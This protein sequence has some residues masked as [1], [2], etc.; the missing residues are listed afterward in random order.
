[1]YDI[2]DAIVAINPNAE[3][4]VIDEKYETIAWR[5]G[6]PVIAKADI[7]AKQLELK[8]AWEAQDYARKRKVEYDKLNQWEMWFD[9]YTKG[10]TVWKDAINAIKAKY[11]KPS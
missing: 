8:K 6:T 5:N 1:M 9:D 11:P 2:V 4:T 10:T 7:E 3:V